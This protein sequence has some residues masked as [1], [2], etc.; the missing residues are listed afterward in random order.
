MYFQG[1][2]R[3]NRCLEECYLLVYGNVLILFEIAVFGTIV[4]RY[5]ISVNLLEQV[6]TINSLPQK[7]VVL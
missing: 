2:F 3:S 1:N 4:H 7:F 5:E 6:L